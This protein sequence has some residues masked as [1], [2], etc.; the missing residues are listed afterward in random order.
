LLLLLS[1]IN[2]QGQDVIEEALELACFFSFYSDVPLS[3]RLWSL[4]VQAASCLVE[5]AL[6]AWPGVLILGDNLISRDTATFLASAAAS[7]SYPQTVFEIV[8]HSLTVDAH[9]EDILC[10]PRLACVVLQNCRG[11]VDQ[12]LEPYLRLVGERLSKPT[13]RALRDELLVLVA[14]ALYYDAA[15]T[16]SVLGASAAPLFGEWFG[17]IFARRKKRET[18]QHFRSL[19]QKRAVAL[20]LVSLLGVPDQVLPAELVAG[21][22]QILNGVLRVLADFKVEEDERAKDLAEE[23]DDEEGGDDDGDDEEDEEDE[24]FA[25][26]E[27]DDVTQRRLR[28]AA[29]SMLGGRGGDADDDDDDDDDSDDWGEEEEDAESP[30]DHVDPFV[31][32]A[33]AMQA[34]AQAAPARAQALAAAGGQQL[35]EAAAL[36]EVRRREAAEAEAKKAVST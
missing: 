25:V 34:L 33:E 19:A 30:L 16:L 6:E 22:P 7:P 12:W 23:D 17:M 29:R 28:A 2:S 26:V 35:A 9:E 1:N 11:G 21:M 15:K 13:S 10:A 8:R 36:A 5:F 3:P 20:G 4:F 32:L 14:N 24:G 27:A 18:S 31:A